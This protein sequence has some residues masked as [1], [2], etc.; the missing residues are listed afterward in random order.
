MGLSLDTKHFFFKCS[1]IV[2]LLVLIYAQTH[3]ICQT[4][5]QL[6][7]EYWEDLFHGIH[8]ELQT[9][10]PATVFGKVI[11]FLRLVSNPQL[12]LQETNTDNNDTNNKSKK[13]NHDLL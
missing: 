8:G 4:E 13:K 10:F 5:A 3:F 11:T 1:D 2:K 9:L 7:K 6:G 12:M